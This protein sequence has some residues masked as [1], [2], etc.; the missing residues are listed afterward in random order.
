MEIAA[1]NP[2]L[3]KPPYKLPVS[4]HNGRAT[5]PIIKTGTLK[6]AAT[7]SEKVR[8]IFGSSFI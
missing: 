5:I 1:M 8:I 6:P 4:S 2:N 3:M 7:T